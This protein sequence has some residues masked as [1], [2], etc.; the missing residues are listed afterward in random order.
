MDLTIGIVDDEP[1]ARERVRQCLEGI[2][3]VEIVCEC[4]DGR[5]AVSTIRHLRPDVIFLD[6]QMPECDGF[7]V[8]AEL[9]E[10]E[11]PQVVFTTAHDR[12]A[13]QAFQ[14]HA[15][16]YLLKP[17]SAKA[18]REALDRA[19]ERHRLR[20]LRALDP[21]TLA[22]LSPAPAPAPAQTWLTRIPVSDGARTRF[23]YPE[24]VECIEAG[25][26][27]LLVLHTAR[28][29]HQIPGTLEHLEERLDPRCFLRTHGSWILNLDQIRALHPA[30]DGAMIAITLG[31]W[32]VPVHRTKRKRLASILPS[33]PS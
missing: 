2:P 1:H 22:S 29:S 18:V 31:G 26:N 8:L 33:L 27:R 9:A 16:D 7:Q 11:R 3:D 21:R 19:R 4:E 12:Y 23:V 17:F 25:S 24:E 15:L 6:I 28:A 5:S 20:R 13:L 30:P 32:K 10:A 14:V